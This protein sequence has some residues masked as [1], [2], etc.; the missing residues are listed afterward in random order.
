MKLA[1]NAF[2]PWKNG[3]EQEDVLVGAPD[4]KPFVVSATKGSIRPLNVIIFAHSEEDAKQRVHH[5]LLQSVEI[6]YKKG[7]KVEFGHRT[8]MIL[9]FFETGNV[10]VEAFDTRFASAI[11]W[12][13]R[14][15]F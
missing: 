4:G 15:I 11:S 3:S 6:D 8:G 1:Y 5:A 9:D 7:E 10:K 2:R 12:D 14:G 13:M